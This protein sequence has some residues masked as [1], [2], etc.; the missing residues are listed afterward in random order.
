M[1][2]QAARRGFRRDTMRIFDELV[3]DDA[4]MIA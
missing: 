2:S 4:S 1:R 3:L